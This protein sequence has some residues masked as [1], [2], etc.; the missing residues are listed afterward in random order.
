M[1]KGD[2]AR[3]DNCVAPSAR[4]IAVIGARHMSNPKGGAVL[5]VSLKGSELQNKI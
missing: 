4:W 3:R 2:I 5:S 1:M